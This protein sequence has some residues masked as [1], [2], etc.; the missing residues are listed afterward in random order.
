[1]DYARYEITWYCVCS[2]LQQDLVGSSPIGWLKIITPT[3]LHM[4][5]WY[6]M[7]TTN[8]DLIFISL[9]R[10][11]YWRTKILWIFDKFLLELYKKH[12][13]FIS[14][15]VEMAMNQL[16]ANHNCQSFQRHV[17]KITII[18]WVVY[19]IFVNVNQWFYCLKLAKPINMYL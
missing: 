15:G 11:H 12:L 8:T 14:C 7:K 4:E 18:T 13:T 6:N 10:I 5:Y 16:A 19:L 17:N 1:M 2:V 3:W 9:L